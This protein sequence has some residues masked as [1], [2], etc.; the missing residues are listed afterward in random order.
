MYI[1]DDILKKCLAKLP[2]L[3]APSAILYISEPIAMEKRLT[4]NR[5]YSEELVAE[6]SAIY[7]TREEY[8]GLFAPLYAEGF[9]IVRS[10]EFFAEDIKQRQETKQWLF[11]LKRN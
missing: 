11:L 1:N 2:A 9:Q 6:Y 8:D 5:F 10:E 3:L 7:R 4:L